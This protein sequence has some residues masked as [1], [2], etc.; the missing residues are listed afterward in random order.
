MA[1]GSIMAKFTAT[2]SAR[3]RGIRRRRRF[4]ALSLLVLFF[5]VSSPGGDADAFPGATPRQREI[6]AELSAFRP[7]GSP[8]T[9]VWMTDV[10]D[11]DSGLEALVA[12][13]VNPGNAAS[14]FKRLAELYPMEKDVLEARGHEARGVD[15][16]MEAA[17]LGFCRFIPDY[18]PE[19]DS[20]DSAQP[21]FQVLRL[22]LQALL[23]RGE[24]AEGRGDPALAERCYQAGLIAGWHLTSDR[25]SALI[26][27]TGVIFKY[28]S[29]QAYAKFLQR[30]AGGQRAEDARRYAE[31]AGTI[32]RAFMWKA[33]TALSEFDGFACLPA[34]I[35]IAGE[36]REVFWRKEAVVRL[37]TLRYGIPQPDNKTI[38][39]NPAFE[40]EADAA[41]MRAA[42]ED[43]EP[44]VRRLAKWLV[45]NVKPKDYEE[46][47]HIFE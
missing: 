30:T 32:M 20:M 29:A 41:L 46:L 26:F 23:A 18:Y 1:I 14:C 7:A 19:F 27:I 22:Y 34:V 13:P 24:A 10:W 36:D 17:G 38:R 2:A 45:L 15:V 39:R 3:L 44:T 12:F 8:E 43:P 6:L 37:A 47:D 21:D 25:S 9:G 4:H 11:T 40:Q 5:H 28:R 16:L 31:R 33:N 35:R 42:S